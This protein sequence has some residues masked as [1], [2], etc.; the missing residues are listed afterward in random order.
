[1]QWLRRFLKAMIVHLDD[2]NVIGVYN[3]GPY[4]SAK[5]TGF[6]GGMRIYWS[7]GLPFLHGI[8][9]RSVSWKLK[10]GAD[11]SQSNLSDD[12]RIIHA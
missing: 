3:T 5:T 11:E 9:K 4:D 6:D 2:V 7:N 10:H 12:V 8:F 1:M